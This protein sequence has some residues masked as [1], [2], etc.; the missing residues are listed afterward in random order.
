MSEASAMGAVVVEDEELDSPL[1]E[2][3]AEL[4]DYREVVQEHGL[5]VEEWT[6]MDDSARL[7]R[8][9]NFRDAVNYSDADQNVKDDAERCADLAG[10]MVELDARGSRDTLEYGAAMWSIYDGLRA[11]GVLLG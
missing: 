8:V 10:H 5:T 6:A 4:T 1:D 2:D 11:L 9:D 7:E 3:L